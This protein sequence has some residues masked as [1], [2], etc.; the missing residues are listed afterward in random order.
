MADK[1]LVNNDNTEKSLKHDDKGNFDDLKVNAVDTSDIDNERFI[2]KAN[3]EPSTTPNPRFG[4][5]KF[6]SWTLK[7]DAEIGEFWEAIGRD[8]KVYRV[9]DDTAKPTKPGKVVIS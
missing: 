4:L 9:V 1:T 3:G 2:K 7:K 8:G 5:P 6:L